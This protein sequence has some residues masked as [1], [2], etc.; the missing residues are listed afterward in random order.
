MAGLG[1][2]RFCR[3]FIAFVHSRVFQLASE[4]NYSFPGMGFAASQTVG[5]GPANRKIGAMS[6]GGHWRDRAAPPARSGAAIEG[7][8][9]QIQLLQL[10]K[11][12]APISVLCDQ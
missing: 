12:Q 2:S 5:E 9:V 8:R 6:L 1:S 7:Q 11:G 4:A 10:Q 3:C